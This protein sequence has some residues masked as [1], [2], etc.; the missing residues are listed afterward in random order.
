V[1]L[2]SGLL[3][4][5]GFT[6]A[7]ADAEAGKVGPQTHTPPPEQESHGWGEEVGFR[8]RFVLVVLSA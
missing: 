1:A 4:W 8:S 7:G 5:M 2:A 3:L 6:G